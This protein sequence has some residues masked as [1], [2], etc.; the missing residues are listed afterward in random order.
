MVEWNCPVFWVMLI[1]QTCNITPLIPVTLHTPKSLCIYKIDSAGY[2]LQSNVFIRVLSAKD[3]TC[4]YPW[5]VM[6][7]SRGFSDLNQSVL[8]RITWLDF[9]CQIYICVTSVQSP[10]IPGFVDL[11]S[12]RIS[13]LQVGN[14]FRSWLLTFCQTFLFHLFEGTF[15]LYFY[16]WNTYTEVSFMIL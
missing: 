9:E 10:C 11:G 3:G 12:K 14:W 13:V 2:D 16:G 15:L 5:N 1:L 6:M 7:E 4:C 8:C